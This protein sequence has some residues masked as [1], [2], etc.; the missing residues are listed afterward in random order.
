MDLASGSDKFA[1]TV[2]LSLEL[3]LNNLVDSFPERKPVITACMSL[4][5]VIEIGVTNDCYLHK[6][7]SAK[8]HPSWRTLLKISFNM[9]CT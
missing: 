7:Q 9:T 8:R 1:R 4:L 6:A 2:F 3:H 5:Q